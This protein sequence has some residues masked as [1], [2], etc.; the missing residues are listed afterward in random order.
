MTNETLGSVYA[1]L[2]ACAWAVGIVLFKRCGRVLKPLALNLHKNIVATILFA[3]TVLVTGQIPT[4]ISLMDVAVIGAS[5]ILGIAIADT[6]FFY[7]LNIVGAG[8][9]A[10][11]D[12]AYSPTVVLLGYLFLDEHLSLLDL[13][14]GALVLTGVLAVALPQAVRASEAKGPVSA[15]PPT[16]STNM[17]KGFA[18]SLLAV[19]IMGFSIVLVKRRIETLPVVWVTL[20]RL[21]GATVCLVALSTLP[22]LRPHLK[23]AI[24][25]HR[26]WR[27]SIPAAFVGS[28]LALTLWIG[29]FKYGQAGTTAILNQMASPVTAIL[30]VVFLRERFSLGMAL[31][32]ALAV[33]GVVL[34][35]V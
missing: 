7:G 4:E 16:Q 34:V 25:P 35:F 3:T 32:L 17:A 19:V 8:R 1:L 20:L 15:A 21:G 10:V 5:G 18:A 28:Y 11:I 14:G 9:Q 31:A 29:G 26:I 12:T 30:A 24:T 2:T 22:R 13:A 6:I 23:Q 33:A 27:H